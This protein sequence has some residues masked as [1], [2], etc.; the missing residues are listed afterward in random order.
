MFLFIRT[1]TCPGKVPSLH[2]Y[3]RHRPSWERCWKRFSA[4]LVRVGTVGRRMWRSGVQGGSIGKTAVGLVTGLG[5]SSFS[6][7][8]AERVYLSQGIN[9]PR[10]LLWGY[11]SRFS[12]EHS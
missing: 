7:N 12:V 2:T 9:W 4:S 10:K 1:E 11:R 6:S 8:E 5:W 3:A